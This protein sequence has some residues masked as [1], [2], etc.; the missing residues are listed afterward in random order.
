MLDRVKEVPLRGIAWSCWGRVSSSRILYREEKTL[1]RTEYTLKRKRKWRPRLSPSCLTSCFT[2]A[3]S[4]VTTVEEAVNFTRRSRAS[5]GV[6][7]PR[8]HSPATPAAKPFV[9]TSCDTNDAG[10]LE[11]ATTALGVLYRVA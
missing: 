8:C 5:T 9:A 11:V 7:V 10:R 1:S 3:L 6:F 2:D 4:Q